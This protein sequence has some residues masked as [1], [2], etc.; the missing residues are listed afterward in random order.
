MAL[1][2]L[3]TVEKRMINIYTAS[4]VKHRQTISVDKIVIQS[5]RIIPSKSHAL[6]KTS[7]I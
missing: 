3:C 5:K 7:N 4:K 2:E 1:Q 6:V